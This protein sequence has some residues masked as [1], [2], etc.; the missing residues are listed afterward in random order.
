MKRGKRKLN[1]VCKLI[2]NA[3]LLRVDIS[4]ST[5]LEVN[6]L[7]KK[8]EVSLTERERATLSIRPNVEL[9]IPPPGF[10]ARKWIKSKTES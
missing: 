6:L 7:K 10:F 8:K 5:K 4:T 2:L 9:I 1:Y 3:I